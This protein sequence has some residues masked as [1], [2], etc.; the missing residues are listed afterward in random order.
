MAFSSIDI[1]LQ[2]KEDWIYTEY[3]NVITEYGYFHVADS[4]R[5]VNHGL[6]EKGKIVVY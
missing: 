1:N 6:L 3:Q 4:I 2:P 5:F